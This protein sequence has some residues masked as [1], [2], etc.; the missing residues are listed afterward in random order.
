MDE[1]S[2]WNVLDL[3]P[4]NTDRSLPFATLLPELFMVDLIWDPTEHFGDTTKVLGFVDTEEQIDLCLLQ[5]ILRIYVLIFER[6]LFLLKIAKSLVQ[7]LIATR[8][9]APDIVFYCF[10][11]I[12]FGI[13]F[14]HIKPR[15]T[16][17]RQIRDSRDSWHHRLLLVQKWWL[18]SFQNWLF[19]LCRHILS[20]F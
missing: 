12:L 9:G 8:S 2:I 16:E 20:D 6:I 5:L 15:H 3:D 18:L 14:Y 17:S 13:W 4:S 10:V 19:L 7:N 1:L 11:N